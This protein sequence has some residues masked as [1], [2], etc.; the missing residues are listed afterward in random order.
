[1]LTNGAH[2]ALLSAAPPPQDRTRERAR[3]KTIQ[4]APGLGEPPSEWRA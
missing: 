4:Q 3:P 1:M 2:L